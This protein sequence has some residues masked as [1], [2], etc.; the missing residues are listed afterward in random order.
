MVRFRANGWPVRLLIPADCGL[1][2]PS[3]GYWHGVTAAN[4]HSGSP[5]E[6]GA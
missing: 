3:C 2:D 6:T 5:S 1:L 4:G